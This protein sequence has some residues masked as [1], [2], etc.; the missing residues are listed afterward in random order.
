MKSSP[1]GQGPR[2]SR[3]PPIAPRN[4]DNSRSLRKNRSAFK[5][6]NVYHYEINSPS[7]ED[8]SF[9]QRQMNGM[10]KSDKYQNYFDESMATP[11]KKVPVTDKQ[12][13]QRYFWFLGLTHIVMLFGVDYYEHHDWILMGAEMMFIFLSLMS[14]ITMKIKVMQIYVLLATIAPIFNVCLLYFGHYQQGKNQMLMLICQDVFYIVLG[15][16][17]TIHLAEKYIKSSGKS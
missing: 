8:E 16:L 1:Q 9:Y 4:I 7:K 11:R 6:S 13:L 3:K 17:V 2:L 14:A 15:C 5:P 12:L 10:I